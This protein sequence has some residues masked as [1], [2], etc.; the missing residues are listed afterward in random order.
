MIAVQIY[1]PLE[2]W[3]WK[4]MKLIKFPPKNKRKIGKGPDIH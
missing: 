4:D 2:A 1:I 3:D